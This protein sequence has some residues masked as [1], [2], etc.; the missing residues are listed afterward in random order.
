MRAPDPASLG[1]GAWV[2]DTCWRL[3]PEAAC[4]R[5]REQLLELRRDRKDAQANERVRL[6]GAADAL[7]AQLAR[8]CG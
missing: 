6:R 4:A 7:A 5:R 8:E 3:P 1:P 2:Q